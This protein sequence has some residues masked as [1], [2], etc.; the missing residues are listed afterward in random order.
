MDRAEI[1]KCSPG[2]LLSDLCCP[3]ISQV[4]VQ[5]TPP[6]CDQELTCVFPQLCLQED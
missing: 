1:P 4:W 2:T 6:V 3:Q 5:P